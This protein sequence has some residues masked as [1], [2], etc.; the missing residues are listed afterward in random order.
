MQGGHHHPFFFPTSS[1]LDAFPTQKDR[2]SIAKLLSALTRLPSLYQ[3]SQVGISTASRILSSELHDRINGLGHQLLCS[4]AYSRFL[5]FSKPQFTPPVSLACAVV[6]EEY[7]RR[8]SHEKN[9]KLTGDLHAA[10]LLH[11]ES[12]VDN[13]NKTLFELLKSKK[14]SFEVTFKFRSILSLTPPLTTPRSSESQGEWAYSMEEKGPQTS[15]WIVLRPWIS[16][17]DVVSAYFFLTI[18]A[19]VL[20][21]SGGILLLIEKAKTTLDTMAADA[22]AD[23]NQTRSGFPSSPFYPQELL[24]LTLLN[25]L[26]ID[27]TLSPALKVQAIFL[28]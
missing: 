10:L 11:C 28:F 3:S 14:S 19:Q 25:T 13:I 24:D 21:F 22:T 2:A 23:V 15:E 1:D 6:S 20:E 16:S 5:L 8:A 27:L 9:S 26:I 12:T 7:C 4:L 17:L 18:F